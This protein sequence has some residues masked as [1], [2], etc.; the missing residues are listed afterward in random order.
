MKGGIHKQNLVKMTKDE[1]E[2]MNIFISN[3]RGKI[4][5][6]SMKASQSYFIE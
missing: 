4:Y 6:Y 2:K 3:K 5:N 1:A